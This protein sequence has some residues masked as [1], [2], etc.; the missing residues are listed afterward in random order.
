[1]L[2]I[3]LFKKYFAPNSISSNSAEALKGQR[4]AER[5]CTYPSGVEKI[6]YFD[7]NSGAV[8]TEREMAEA[9]L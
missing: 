3:Y 1:M 6:L 4:G 2:E 7:L 9:Q 8:I 5:S